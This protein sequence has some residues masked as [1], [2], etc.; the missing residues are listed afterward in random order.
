MSKYPRRRDDNERAIV[1][2]LRKVGASVQAIDATG[3]PDLLVGY[4]GATYLLEVKQL[5][6]RPG[7][8]MRKTTSGLRESQ[9]AWFAAWRGRAPAIVTTAHEALIAI[10]AINR[11][12]NVTA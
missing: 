9:D 4:K 5:V 2:A 1:V 8:G 7:V 10:G 12:G 11:D 3:V 6:G